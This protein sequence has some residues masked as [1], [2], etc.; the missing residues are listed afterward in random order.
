[1]LQTRDSR[2][3]LGSG[4]TSDGA[5]LHPGAKLFSGDQRRGW[6]KVGRGTRTNKHTATRSEEAW[7]FRNGCSGD[8]WHSAGARACATQPDAHRHW[9]GGARCLPRRFPAPGPEP[10]HSCR[11]ERQTS[12][13]PVG[14]LGGAGLP[15]FGLEVGG[16]GVGPE[17]GRRAG[18]RGQAGRRRPS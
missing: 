11:A 12:G 18:R 14:S 5:R 17:M 3:S 7:L 9:K 16:Q 13:S 15:F 2:R 4:R 6:V 10:G 1:M 8:P